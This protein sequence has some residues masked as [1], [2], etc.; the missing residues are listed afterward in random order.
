MVKAG[1]GA[2]TVLDLMRDSRADFG[3]GGAIRYP[4]S[5]EAGA[6]LLSRLP[7]DLESPAGVLLM[8]A[9]KDFGYDGAAIDQER[10]RK[11][12]YE[13]DAPLRRTWGG[14]FARKLGVTSSR[15]LQM[16]F[17]LGSLQPVHAKMVAY[18]AGYVDDRFQAVA[19]AVD[20]PAPGDDAVVAEMKRFFLAAAR[21]GTHHAG[22]YID[23]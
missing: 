10:G 4:T 15:F 9:I 7:D 13:L 22:V 21:A 16:T 1:N 8:R 5:A 19:T 23:A 11:E 2:A 6:W 17:G 3:C 20:A 12:L 14:S 18:F